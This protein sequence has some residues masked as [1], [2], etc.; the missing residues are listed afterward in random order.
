MQQVSQEM[1][2]PQV[3]SVVDGQRVEQAARPVGVSLAAADVAPGVVAAL[4][5][6]RLYRPA[7]LSSLP[8]HTT[9]E[10]EP[11]D[12]LVGQQRA[13]EAIGF[14]TRM[15]KPGF[16][17]FVIGPSEGRMQ[18]TVESVLRAAAR[19]KPIPPDWVY[20]NNFREP[21]KPVAIELPAGRA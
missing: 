4:A 1:S 6:D 3:E 21:H 11:I 16:N 13:A 20:V 9:A 10:L 5:A 19:E 8:F 12:G 14:G 17:L 18:Q 7:D 2:S 15:R